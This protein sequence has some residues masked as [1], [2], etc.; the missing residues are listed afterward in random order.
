MVKTIYSLD[1]SAPY[2]LLCQPLNPAK[3]AIGQVL[4]WKTLE[5]PA[6]NYTV[7]RWSRLGKLDVPSIIERK[8]TKWVAF[9]LGIR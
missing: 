6:N 8:L 4:W 2:V 9:S 1:K 5:A 3:G 7:V